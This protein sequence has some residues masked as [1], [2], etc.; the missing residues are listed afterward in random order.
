MARPRADTR[1][2][3]TV[4][5]PARRVTSNHSA[6]HS[7]FAGSEL[8]L[9]IPDLETHVPVSQALAWTAAG[10]ESSADIN[11]GA[12]LVK[13]QDRLKIGDFWFYDD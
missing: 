12:I 10:F 1:L 5:F 3:I 6:Q 9:E 13:D 8:A 2:Q 11:M 7:A 4:A